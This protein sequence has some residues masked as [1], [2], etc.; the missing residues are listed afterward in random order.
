MDAAFWGKARPHEASGARFH[1]L[2]FH[3][4]DVAAVAE[5]L[6]DLYPAPTRG[7]VEPSG[8]SIDD[9]RRLLVRLVALHD[10][11]KYG[12]GFQGKVDRKSVV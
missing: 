1:A 8:A 11:G 10:I 7:L 5:I 3:A 2:A 12:R 9:A 6:V 4:L